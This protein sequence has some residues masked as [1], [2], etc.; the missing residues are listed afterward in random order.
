MTLF[1]YHFL[2]SELG[3]L[4]IGHEFDHYPKQMLRK[5][6]DWNWFL[7]EH[8]KDDSKE[9][10][11]DEDEKTKL[12]LKKR[13]KR[14]KVGGNN[15]DEED[16]DWTGESQEEK[17]DS[18]QI[19]KARKNAY[20]TRSKDRSFPSKRT[21]GGMEKS[22]QQRASGSRDKDDVD[23]DVD[24]DEED[25]MLGGFIVN[26]DDVKQE[27]EGEGDLE[28]EEE[29]IEDDEEGFR[30]VDFIIYDMSMSN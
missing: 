17:Q 6:K 29:F 4:V 27:E 13:K 11:K 25:E 23:V 26:D 22:A 19:A 15:E 14:K 5:V 8:K 18:L 20:F 1:A 7:E 12:K 30:W 21:K 16:D 9:E 2:V 28:E 10:N 3:F 24:V